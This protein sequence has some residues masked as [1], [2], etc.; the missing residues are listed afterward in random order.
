M[1]GSSLCCLWESHSP[2]ILTINSKRS[3]D[4]YPILILQNDS[5]NGF[6]SLLYITP[7][8]NFTLTIDF[9][10]HEK[11]NFKT[12]FFTWTFILQLFLYFS[13]LCF[14]QVSHIEKVWKKF[15]KLFRSILFIQNNGFTVTFS[16]TKH[17]CSHFSLQ[18]ILSHM[19]IWPL[20]HHFTK[21]FL[22]MSPETPVI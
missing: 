14:S 3:L 7:H 17:S 8:I 10:I 19:P 12:F 18:T 21:E 1:C 4:F 6:L 16:Y 11:I 13:L 9:E 2:H 20:T 15:S 22:P 5:N